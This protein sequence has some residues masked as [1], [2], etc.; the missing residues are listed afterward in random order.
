[1]EEELAGEKEAAELR[2]TEVAE[3]A[4]V[5]SVGMDGLHQTIQDMREEV[6]TWKAKSQDLQVQLEV[7]GLH[8][9]E[10][11]QELIRSQWTID[12]VFPL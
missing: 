12:G 2:A 9:D 10:K 11:E 5:H 1:M 4:R 8:L 7:K 6:V 3:T